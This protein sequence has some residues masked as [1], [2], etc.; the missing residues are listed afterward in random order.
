MKTASIH[1]VWALVIGAGV[2]PANA[3]I[4]YPTETIS[5]QQAYAPSRAYTGAFDTFI[6]S[7]SPT[8]ASGESQ[9]LEVDGDPER[10]AL[11]R[12][13]IP[14]ISVDAVVTRASITL[15]ILDGSGDS[16]HLFAVSREW[17]A[18]GATW[19]K[20]GV[21]GWR[22]KGLTGLG[23]R[24][25]IALGTLESPSSGLHA[26][27]LNAAGLAV[28]QFWAAHPERNFGVV[29][30]PDVNA[31]DGLDI[32]AAESAAP[33][34]RP[35][36]ELEYVTN[37]VT[38]L[39]APPEARVAVERAIG[40]APFQVQF[41]ASDSF[42]PDGTIVAAEWDFGN[43]S[44]ASGLV[45]QTT[46][47]TQGVHTAWLHLTDEQGGRT[48]VAIPVEATP[49]LLATYSVSNGVNG[50]AGMEDTKIKD[51]APTTAFGADP[52]MEVDGDPDYG[53]LMRWD[54]SGLPPGALVTD[55]SL[56]LQITNL[57]GDAYPLFAMSRDWDEATATWEEAA[58]GIPWHVP[59]ASGAND[60]ATDILGEIR[61]TLSGRRTL[62]FTDAGVAAF[63]QWADDPSTNFGLIAQ[64][65]TTAADG[66]DFFSSDSPD[67]T[68]RP[69]LTVSYVEPAILPPHTPP[70]L[71]ISDNA[72]GTEQ[73]VVTFTATSQSATSIA[74][75]IDGTS[76]TG[77]RTSHQF[78][79]PG[80]YAV[81]AKAYDAENGLTVASSSVLISSASYAPVPLGVQLP[82]QLDI[83]SV[84]PN[85]ATIG[86]QATI[87]W[88]AN[89]VVLLELYDMLG[90]RL[91]SRQVATTSET[92][93]ATLL[94]SDGLA[95]GVYVL[96]ARSLTGNGADTHLFTRQ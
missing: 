32:A 10:L 34:R 75:D 66:V 3:Q 22:N 46:Y 51:D 61:P 4:A 92:I 80:R 13:S 96:Q 49:P 41:N 89:D 21:E 1:M 36:L 45:A 53:T 48:S 94:P 70:D 95:R 84:F 29:L 71:A 55:V 5:Y 50:Y 38:F 82:S 6:A 56:S 12:W 35:R 25:I 18:D 31:T 62:E 67:V 42:D 93:G 43:G 52:N 86:A 14:D 9:V 2:I 65:Y 63:Q 23:D 30:V 11:L 27:E 72:P 91:W 40:R 76:S 69:I 79:A 20:T 19:E 57:S 8:V 16:F 24:G 54:L 77:P 15:D 78:L 59:G 74:W 64:N 37:K 73:S 83:L 39:N 26:I 60:H 44:T 33:E 81:T 85:P 17:T 90:R 88:P 7:A 28:I 68:T 47:D 87:Q 58:A